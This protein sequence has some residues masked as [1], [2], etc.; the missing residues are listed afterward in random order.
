MNELDKKYSRVSPTPKTRLKISDSLMGHSVSEEA[1]QKMRDN[2][3]GGNGKNAR[4]WKGG[5]YMNSRGYEMVYVGTREG[6]NKSGYMAKHRIVAEESLGRK[7]L[8]DEVVHHI[9]GVRWDN[10]PENLWVYDK[11][12][13]MRIHSENAFAIL[14]HF[15]LQG[16][17]RFEN[18]R[19]VINLK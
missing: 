2:Y 12:E 13:H 9:N 7:L 3:S 19:Y 18:G 11:R 5:E 8:P 10:S 16:D 4:H 14:R 1:K 17:V 15:Y 6:A